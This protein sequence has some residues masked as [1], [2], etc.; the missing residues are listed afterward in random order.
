VTESLQHRH[1]DVTGGRYLVESTGKHNAK[2]T[3]MNTNITKSAVAIAVALA[4][5]TT[6]YLAGAAGHSQAGP[7]QN[8]PDGVRPAQVDQVEVEFGQGS[9]FPVHA[10]VAVSLPGPGAQIYAISQRLEGSEFVITVLAQGPAADGAVYDTLPY[11]TW[12]PLNMAGLPAGSYTVSV[13]G[14]RASF[15]F[16][17]PAG[18]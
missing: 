17:P 8:L 3:A 11:K 14:A 13:N 9:P 4:L 18:G 15:D 5:A 12:L 16:P 6:A 10:A 2:E 1:T 7:G